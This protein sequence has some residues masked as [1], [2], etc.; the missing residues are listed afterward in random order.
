MQ[1]AGLPSYHAA[2]AFSLLSKR[3]S[4]LGPAPRF[5]AIPRR[6]PGVC[7]SRINITSVDTVLHCLFLGDLRR[8]WDCQ[9]T[10]INL[11]CSRAP[12][13]THKASLRSAP[14][15][16]NFFDT[17][18]KKVQGVRRC[19]RKHSGVIRYLPVQERS[20]ISENRVD[21]KIG[22]MHTARLILSAYESVENQASECH[23]AWG[24]C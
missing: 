1:F 17:S 21:M 13:R 20:Q 23:A 8:F 6:R 11:E 7:Y 22:L 15:Q 9:S 19:A 14:L 3:F 16:F 10:V 5:C 4:A 12:R 2:A 24:C 18:M